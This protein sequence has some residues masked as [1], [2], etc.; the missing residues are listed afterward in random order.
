M[1][2]RIDRRN[3]L[4]VMAATAAGAAA[5][6]TGVEKALA[7]GA[8]RAT[9]PLNPFEALS[10]MPGPTTSIRSPLAPGNVA[11]SLM[12]QDFKPTDSSFGYTGT[13]ATIWAVGGLPGTTLFRAQPTCLMELC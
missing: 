7:A 2:S 10:S 13:L 5:S 6:A 1:S 11:L 12:G 4:K 9:S 8:P 3:M